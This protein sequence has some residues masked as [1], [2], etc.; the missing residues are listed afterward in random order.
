MYVRHL[1][2]LRT[3]DWI[4]DDFP[5]LSI[6][7]MK[8]G[9]GN[10]EIQM[11]D[12]KFSELVIVRRGRL[13]HFRPGGT[14][15]LRTGDFFVIHPGGKHGYA[16]LTD[17]AMIYNILYD[18]RLPL[19]L[20]TC[21]LANLIYP[22]CG[23]ADRNG[24]VIARVEKRHLPRI[25]ALLAYMQR[26][27]QSRR[28][29]HSRIIGA[30]FEV[31]VLELSRSFRPATRHSAKASIAPA[32]EYANA[33]LSEKL[34]VECLAK[35]AHMPP[36][37]LFRSFRAQL[38]TTP[39]QYLLSLRAARAKD[40]LETTG[41][42]LARIARMSGFHD[43]S[44]LIRTMKRIYGAAEGKRPVI[45]ARNHP[46]NGDQSMVSSMKTKP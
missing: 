7:T 45:A 40:L 9:P 11:H 28:E 46:R 41:L 43:A 35:T 33:H 30:L 23:T 14:D 26:E 37:M 16:D 32:I 12:H 18:D 8:A 24:C 19:G 20:N 25:D 39:C 31:L 42:T 5:P 36:S 3:E 10:E 21:R 17:D 22:S 6:R 44:H 4:G 29:G 1:S 38:G 2:T 13:T 34:T 15:R 27:M